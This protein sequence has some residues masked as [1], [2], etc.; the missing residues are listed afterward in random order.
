LNLA[1]PLPVG[2]A[3]ERELMDLW[4]DEP[5]PAEDV[6]A[7]LGAALPGG[8]EVVDVTPVDE[9][10]PSLQSASRAARYAVRYEA[11]SVD[12]DALAASVE[13]FLALETLPWEEERGERT[14]SYDLR[15]AVLDAGVRAEDGATVLELRLSLRDGGG[16]ARP[17]SVAS[18]LGLAGVEPL[19]TTRVAI[20]L[21]E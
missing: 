8:L 7:R 2:T 13:R 18:A 17:S 20:E 21:E 3:A 14:R 1:A 6:S 15:Q 5:V 19:L 9:R 16:S 4:L 11:S 12:T 10:V